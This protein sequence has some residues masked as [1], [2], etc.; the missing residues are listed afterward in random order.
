MAVD[1]HTYQPP[2]SVVAC[3]HAFAFSAR[4]CS[5]ATLTSHLASSGLAVAAALF[6]FPSFFVAPLLP[7]LFL[8]LSPLLSFSTLSRKPSP[9]V[10][11][12]SSPLRSLRFPLPAHPPFSPFL[13][14]RLFPRPSPARNSRRVVAGS[15]V[16]IVSP[17]SD[18]SR[19]VQLPASRPRF[20]AHH[21]VVIVGVSC[22]SG[23]AWRSWQ[24]V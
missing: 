17:P 7:P 18:R 15:R 6:P 13:R 2:S 11:G 21:T 20:F 9:Y 19:R 4:R 5:V 16:P 1:H 8:P 22:Y 24:W 23:I 10:C 12:L 3:M 14:A